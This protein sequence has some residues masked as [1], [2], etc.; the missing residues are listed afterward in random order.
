MERHDTHAL[1]FYSSSSNN[2]SYEIDNKEN[3]NKKSKKLSLKNIQDK[4]IEDELTNIQIKQ[5]NSILNKYNITSEQSLKNEKY[6]K[7]K[8][9]TENNKEEEINLDKNILDS[10][11]FTGENNIFNSN[12]DKKKIS[13]KER[14]RKSLQLKKDYNMNK[15]DNKEEQKKDELNNEGLHIGEINK[16]E[17]KKSHSINENF[18]YENKKEKLKYSTSHR[19]TRFNNIQKNID[20]E[21]KRKMKLK[22]IYDKNKTKL[23]IYHPVNKGNNLIREIK[24]PPISFITKIFKGINDI[25][26]EQ[27]EKEEI[28][29]LLLSVKNS[30][31]FFTKQYVRDKEFNKQ[32]KIRQYQKMKEEL[33]DEKIPTFSSINTSSSNSE[34]KTKSKS[35]SKKKQSKNKAKIKSKNLAKKKQNIYPKSVKQQRSTSVYSKVSKEKSDEGK[36]T[37]LNR[38]KKVIVPNI[39]KKK[40]YISERKMAGVNKN[41]RKFNVINRYQGKFSNKQ[42]DNDKD[43]DK[44]DEN[45]KIIVNNDKENNEI[46]FKRFL[47]E[48]KIKKNKQIKNYIKKNGITSYHF[49]Y[50][51]EPSPLLSTFKNK[52]NVYPTLN[53]DR[54][55]SLDMG[56]NNKVIINNRQFY[57][58][59][60]QPKKGK[61]L[62][63]IESKNLDDKDNKDLYS[64]N[65][66]HLI[67]KHY[68]LE[69]DCPLCRA[70]QMR[71]LK[72]DY[73]TMNFIRTMKY[74]KLKM[75]EKMPRIL[76]PNSFGFIN[77]GDK[78][79]ST[80]SRNRNS[81]A[82][83]SEYIDEYSQ[84]KKNF[85]VL[86]DYFNQ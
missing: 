50:P 81:S 53:V 55:S 67:D 64:H 31:S 1:S 45:E 27:I 36:K 85:V 16:E 74:R 72:D 5:I 63:E 62:F 22:K 61:T 56:N 41:I 15:D 8:Q 29:G 2:H 49:F 58:I 24:K 47:E 39:K 73:N 77:G 7:Y 46:D 38:K 17:Q 40:S 48:Q 70:F 14:K 18:I 9:N 26:N 75:S 59:K 34:H 52:Y 66:I 33:K 44:V 11:N 25:I 13:K 12:K 82:R 20:D 84:I 28:P 32:I 65:S 79:Y 21:N 86:I 37:T 3:T 68:G 19:D 78:D 69:K 42:K 23:L 83:K 35:K 71:K 76:S 30:Y 43:K 57:K 54:K 60:S 6:N 10:K 4:R 51:K 80:L